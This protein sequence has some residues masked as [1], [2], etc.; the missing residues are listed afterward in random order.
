MSTTNYAGIDDLLQQLQAVQRRRWAIHCGAGLCAL[1]AVAGASLVLAA[2]L[3]GYW[4]GQPPGLLRWAVL[5]VVAASLLAAA[6]LFA[7]HV[8]LWR[9]TP[10]QT[11]LFVERTKAGLRNNLINAVLLADDTDQPSSQLVQQAIDESARSARHVDFV[12]AVPARPLKRWALTAGCA[13]VAVLLL[14]TLQGG[15]LRRGM[16]AAV[17]P[18]SYVPHVNDIVAESVTPGDVTVFTGQT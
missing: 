9:Q 6:A 2:A 1:C 12:R 11:A 14:A 8:L 4:P 16:A 13:V 18:G 7:R 17:S 15:A 3:L 5:A 10:A